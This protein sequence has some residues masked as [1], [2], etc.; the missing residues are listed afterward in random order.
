[1]S[2]GV[3][4]NGELMQTYADKF[5]D[6][7]CKDKNSRYRSYDYI[8][9]FYLAKRSDNRNKTLDKV[10]LRLFAF[11]GSWGMLCRGAFLMQKDYR[12]LIP[13]I[14]ILNKT[15]Y[16]ELCNVDLFSF[17]IEAYIRKVIDL[18]KEL[19]D[20]FI[21]KTYYNLK[22]PYRINKNSKDKNKKVHDTVI[23]KI[24]MATLGC[25]PAYDEYVVDGMK[26]EKLCAT[27]GK[28][29]LKKLVNY[30]RDHKEALEKIMGS[31][32]EKVHIESGN[33]EL[34]YFNANSADLL[35]N[36]M[37]RL[38]VDKKLYALGSALS[39][40]LFAFMAIFSLIVY[41]SSPAYKKE[42]TYK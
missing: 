12:F 2:T 7:Y 35:I 20:Y 39:L 29:S 19:N 1:M 4:A 13:V 31:V 41:V 5:M 22:G 14:K 34:N 6:I 27:L 37:Y 26:N 25:I 36:W 38:T 3:L 11:L 8:H 28:R 18:K 42:D 16:K 15:D 40:I 17:D 23:G 9:S 33:K 30:S 10:A 24:L 21:D 32:N